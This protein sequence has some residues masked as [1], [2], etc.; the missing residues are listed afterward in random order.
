VTSL[1]RTFHTLQSAPFYDHGIQLY[2]R[3]PRS[4]A[5]TN[6]FHPTRSHLLT[7]AQ[8]VGLLIGAMFFEIDAFG[9]KWTF[10]PHPGHYGVFKLIA[11]SFPNFA[12]MVALQLFGGLTFAVTCLWILLSSLSSSR[13]RT[14]TLGR[15]FLLIR[16]PLGQ[17]PQTDAAAALKRKLENVNVTLIRALF[18]RRISASLAMLFEL[19]QVKYAPVHYAFRFGGS[20]TA[21]RARAKSKIDYPL[22]PLNSRVW[23]INR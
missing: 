13:V 17:G 11:S 10:K 2:M 16:P 22:R 1:T 3:K 20:V 14:S 4:Y 12:V 19:L 21:L 15:S 8:N 5:I 9:R 18:A 23:S 6:E 7:L